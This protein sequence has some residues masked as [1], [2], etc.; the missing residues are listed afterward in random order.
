[1]GR[2]SGTAGVYITRVSEGS[3]KAAG[4]VSA[5]G[6]NEMS[7]PSAARASVRGVDVR[8]Y[9]ATFLPLARK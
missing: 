9:P 6:L 7:T 3:R 1:M 4:M 8:S 5:S 2:S